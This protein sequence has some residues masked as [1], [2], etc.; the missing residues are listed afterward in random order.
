[1]VKAKLF[2]AVSTT[3]LLVLNTSSLFLAG[4]SEAIQPGEVSAV[5]ARHHLCLSGSS[6]WNGAILLR[7][8]WRPKKLP[9]YRGEI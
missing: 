8:K 2:T 4:S 3:L 5:P 7:T 1:V 9:E 6:V